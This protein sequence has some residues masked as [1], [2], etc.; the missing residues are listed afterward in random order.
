[1]LAPARWLR[2]ADVFPPSWDVTSDSVAAFVAG[3]LDVERLVVVKPVSGG[4]ELLDPYFDRACPAGLRVTI[5][6]CQS[7]HDLAAAL[8]D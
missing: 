4:R 3:A 7:P 8:R 2:A 1:V 5:V 6:G